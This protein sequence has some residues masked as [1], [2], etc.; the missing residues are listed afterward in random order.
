MKGAR[1]EAEP[2]VFGSALEALFEFGIGPRLDDGAK[3]RLLEIGIDLSRP[4]LAAYT[5]EQWVQALWIAAESV[6]PGLSKEESEFQL[7]RDFVAGVKR[8]LLGKALWAYAAAVG[9]RRA[10]RRMSSNSR[11]FNNFTEL[12]YVEDPEGPV[13]ETRVATALLP[14]V[15][16]RSSISPEYLRGVLHAILE[17]S[18]RK[19]VY[20]ERVANNPALRLTRFR[21]HFHE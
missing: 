21:L 14:K 16:G 8:T 12:E 3:K 15:E 2:V 4:F 5:V 17:L 6:Y 7:G 18:G 1:I 20:V 19:E 9:P 10:M 13:M 11:S